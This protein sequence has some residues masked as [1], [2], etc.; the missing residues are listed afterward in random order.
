MKGRGCPERHTIYTLSAHY[1]CTIYTICRVAGDQYDTG[2]DI[3]HY[4]DSTQILVAIGSN[5][6]PGRQASFS[7]DNGSINFN[8]QVGTRRYVARFMCV[9]CKN[10]SFQ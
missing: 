9:L 7:R 3:S 2:A 1:L 5:L 10:I 4:Q 6:T 8:Q